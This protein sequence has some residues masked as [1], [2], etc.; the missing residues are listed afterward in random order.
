MLRKN[1]FFSRKKKT[2]GVISTKSFNWNSY[3]T[4]FISN[5]MSELTAVLLHV[6]ETTDYTWKISVKCFSSQRGSTITSPIFVQITKQIS[7][8]QTGILWKFSRQRGCTHELIT[9]DLSYPRT[10][11]VNLSLLVCDKR[12]LCT[13]HTDDKPRLQLSCLTLRPFNVLISVPPTMKR[14]RR[15]SSFVIEIHSSNGQPLTYDQKH[16]LYATSLASSEYILQAM[17]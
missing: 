11:P 9:R 13:S 16:F 3:Q 8:Q 17:V 10:P 12:R 4:I 5:R 7:L 1:F 14:T 15:R 2:L 6:D